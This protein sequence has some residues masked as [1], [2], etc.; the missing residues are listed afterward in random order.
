MITFT[1]SAKQRIRDILSRE[2]PGLS[3]RI[4]VEG[5]GCNGLNYG[6][7]LTSQAEDDDTVIELDSVRALIDPMS[8]QYMQG[9]EVDFTEN[10]S[11]ANFV[12]KNPNATSK[13]GCGS[14]FA[15]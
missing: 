10:L 2:E 8:L 11:G 5:G 4:F 1:A 15:V 12:I 14:S 13:C 6:F 9:S 3:L 7:T